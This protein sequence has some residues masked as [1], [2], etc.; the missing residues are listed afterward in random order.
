MDS[1]SFVFALPEIS[2]K[3]TKETFVI[4][5]PDDML[6]DEYNNNLTTFNEKNGPEGNTCLQD[7]MEENP[8]NKGH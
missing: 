2:H 7:G 5:V 8:N 1:S 4:S 3:E 6:N